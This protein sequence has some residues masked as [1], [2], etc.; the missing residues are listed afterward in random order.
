DTTTADAMAALG[1]MLRRWRFNGRRLKVNVTGDAS[2]IQRKTSAESRNGIPKTDQDQ[3]RE[4]FARHSS[5]FEV[6]YHFRSR[7][8]GQRDRCGKV[9][10]AFR[11]GEVRI[12]P[13]CRALVND[14]KSVRWRRDTFGNVLD[15]L[16]KRSP[17]LTHASDAFS[18]MVIA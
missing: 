15:V 6:A 4:Y 13:S 12:H 7:N 11:R 1:E 5:T 8:L 9:N 3:V 10:N 2:S 17:D 16:D 14:L 18:Y